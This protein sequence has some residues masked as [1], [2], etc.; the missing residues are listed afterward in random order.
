MVTCVNCGNMHTH[1][2]E[3]KKRITCACCNSSN[4]AYDEFYVG[5]NNGSEKESSSKFNGVVFKDI[6]KGDITE[7]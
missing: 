4:L 6:S 5:E 1:F 7:I 2:N 3:R